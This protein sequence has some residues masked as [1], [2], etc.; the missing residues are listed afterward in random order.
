MISDSD[1][2]GIAAAALRIN[3]SKELGLTMSVVEAVKEAAIAGFTHEHARRVCEEA[4]RQRYESAHLGATGSDRYISFDPPIPD[5]VVSSLFDQRKEASMPPKTITTRSTP[6]Y[7]AYEIPDMSKVAEV[8]APA[9]S[10]ARVFAQLHDM[11]DDSRAKVA[12]LRVGLAKIAMDCARQ[13]SA[14]TEILYAMTHANPYGPAIDEDVC[15][16]AR[17]LADHGFPI[18]SGVKVGFD[19]D[20]THPL[21]QTAAMLGQEILNLRVRETALADIRR[22]LS[23]RVGAC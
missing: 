5:T 17:G 22:D 16:I 6:L 3:Q 23:G 12:G 2:R 8:E 10:H 20:P 14:V 4:Y 19:L 1:I 13:G 21:P 7:R 15:K 18:G 11:V 9:P